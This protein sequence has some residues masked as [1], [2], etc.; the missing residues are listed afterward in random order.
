VK[1][2]L[3]HKNVSNLVINN[4][5]V[6]EKVF[7]NA[8]ILFIYYAFQNALDKRFPSASCDV[9]P[10]ILTVKTPTSIVSCV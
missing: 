1:T 4:K 6:F 2:M 9:K 10:L 3:R 7:I 8:S 5:C